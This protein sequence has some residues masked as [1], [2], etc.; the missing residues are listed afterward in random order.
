MAAEISES[1]NQSDY[2][3]NHSTTLAFLDNLRNDRSNILSLST[4]SVKGQSTSI[5]ASSTG[6]RTNK[7]CKPSP[8][9][10]AYLETATRYMYDPGS[11]GNLNDVMHKYDCDIK[12]E[13]DAFDK[14][15]EALKVSGDDYNYAM[16]KEAAKPC[17]TRPTAI[18]AEWEC[19]YVT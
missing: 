18:L 10:T 8:D 11:L 19:R 6:A 14:T 3:H 15:N 16:T 12:S 2:Q 13:Q 7:V 1:I 4:D 5:D 17:S 9:Y